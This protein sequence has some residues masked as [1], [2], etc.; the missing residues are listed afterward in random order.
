MNQKRIFW[1]L[2][3]F[4]LL[5]FL[6]GCSAKDEVAV[7]ESEQGSNFQTERLELTLED[8][9]Y[10]YSIASHDRKLALFTVNTSENA[11]AKYKLY[12]KDWVTGEVE[13]NPYEFGDNK[14]ILL[15]W[16]EEESIT[17]LLKNDDSA[18]SDEYLLTRIDTQGNPLSEAEL[19]Q[20]AGILNSEILIKLVTDKEGNIYFLGML[21]AFC[22]NPDHE[23]LTQSA[24]SIQ[25][26]NM[27]RNQSGDVL[28]AVYDKD[29]HTEIKTG[30][31]TTGKLKSVVKLPELDESGLQELFPSKDYDFCCSTQQAVY[32]YD[33]EEKSIYKLLDFENADVDAHTIGG[34]CEVSEDAFAFVSSNPERK[35]DMTE[36]LVLSRQ[37]QQPDRTTL[38]M[39]G[40]G[41]SP[42]LKSAV[43]K[44]NGSSQ[45]YRIEVVD[46][47]EYENADAKITTEMIAGDGLDLLCLNGLPGEEYINRNLLED[48]YTYID[49]DADVSKEDFIES[50][51][52]VLEH[53]GKLLYITPGFGISTAVGRSALLGDRIGMK[54]EEFQRILQNQPDDMQPFFRETRDGMLNHLCDE[55]QKDIHLDDEIMRYY[56]ETARQLPESIPDDS[57]LEAVK[58]NRFLMMKDTCV[59]FNDLMIYQRIFEEDVAFTGYPTEKG[60][61]NALDCLGMNV[62]L[63]SGSAN[64]EAAWDFIK[65]LLSE[66]FQYYSYPSFFPTRKDCM[67]RIVK[68]V[69][70]T[71]EYDDPD[72]NHVKPYRCEMT[73]D[74]VEIVLEPMTTSEEEKF[75]QLLSSIEYEKIPDAKTEEIVREEAEG[76]FADERTA[77]ETIASIKERIGLL[78]DELN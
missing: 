72:G 78:F 68:M 7:R 76:F 34:I 35:E 75:W 8:G 71:E 24:D 57:L 29:L 27:S 56:L 38:K 47:G 42:L 13:E 36:V 26:V 60:N 25:V 45:E 14:C 9:E 46:Y 55:L 40:I 54:L 17:M 66:D 2:S 3:F 61:G 33:A 16:D 58:R 69:S 37:G 39:G 18:H 28:F 22:W 77:D 74:D 62:G 30:D 12:I 1:A 6:T 43:S 70:A 32:G 11:S 5:L 44:Y 52:K 53:D 10:V 23:T 64:K 21:K 19:S 67:D 31:I 65:I 50:V 41:I 51:L 59:E 63:C 4:T 48:L 20:Y 15:T 49:R 73:Y